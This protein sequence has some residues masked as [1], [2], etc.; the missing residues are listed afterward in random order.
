MLQVQWQGTL[1]PKKQPLNNPNP[2]ARNHE[3]ALV[4]CTPAGSRQRTRALLPAKPI[5]FR[6]FLPKAWRKVSHSGG[7]DGMM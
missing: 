7:F 1:N 3:A 5:L 4:S 6:E 2:K